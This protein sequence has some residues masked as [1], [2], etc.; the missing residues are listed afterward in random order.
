MNEPMTMEQRWAPA[1]RVLAA[2]LLLDVMFVGTVSYSG[3]QLWQYKHHATR[4]T[5]SLDEAGRAWEV[6]TVGGVAA[7]I[8][9]RRQSL[10]D[11]LISLE[12]LTLAPQGKGWNVLLSDTSHLCKTRADAYALLDLD[13]DG[14][15]VKAD[16]RNA[17]KIHYAA[18]VVCM[19]DTT[20]GPH[21]LM[22]TRG[23]Q[24]Y[25]AMRALPGGRVHLAETSKAAA[26]RVLREKTGVTVDQDRV[27]LLGV[28][29]D[30]D[31]DPRCRMVSAAYGVVL[32]HDGPPETL[33]CTTAGDDA[34]TAEWLPLFGIAGPVAFDHVDIIS[35]GV[36]QL[37]RSGRTA[38]ILTMLAQHD[39]PVAVTDPKAAGDE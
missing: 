8:G 5:L 21:I 24:P 22:I 35:A 3:R 39:G 15:S 32:E 18:D 33:P 2:D 31:R 37:L 9:A 29:D 16:T 6:V 36:V 26:V 38:G 4:R 19:A 27:Q 12:V 25:Q 20:D 11:A 34:A 10:A 23:K 28:Y 13:E 1:E 30:P 7:G 14:E 17:E